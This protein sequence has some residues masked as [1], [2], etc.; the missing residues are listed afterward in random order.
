MCFSLPS[1]YMECKLPPATSSSSS[2]S[3]SK[4]WV[5]GGEETGRARIIVRFASHL[6]NDTHYERTSVV[7]S[8]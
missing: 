7:K 4:Q 5:L 6:H 1:I 3:S 8:N 2:S